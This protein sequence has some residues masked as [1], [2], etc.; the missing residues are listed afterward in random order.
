MGSACLE[1]ITRACGTDMNWI[2]TTIQSHLREERTKDRR[3]L[4]EKA[5]PLALS[6][7][8]YHV[9]TKFPTRRFTS[10]QDLEAHAHDHEMADETRRY[11]RNKLAM[12]ALRSNQEPTDFQ[13]DLYEICNGGVMRVCHMGMLYRLPY[14]Y[15]EDIK[16]AELKEH[17][18][19]QPAVPTKHGTYGI[20]KTTRELLRHSRIFQSRR[21]RE[22]ME[23]WFHDV[24]TN[25]AVRW[26][27]AYDNPLRSLV[28]Q[29]W[30]TT[31]RPKIHAR[32]AFTHDR[33]DDFCYWTITEPELRFE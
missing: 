32:W 8:A 33:L 27:V 15:V 26:P 7:A 11:Y 20:E 17:T 1:N 9:W 12:R 23:Y 21:N 24:I 13:K 22:V 31:A 16:R 6:W 2:D 18:L 5:D 3:P 14:F 4:T 30:Q 25:E 19:A 10:W 29:H 28:E